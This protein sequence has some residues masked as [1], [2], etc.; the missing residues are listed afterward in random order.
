L[1][2]RPRDQVP[3]VSQRE[4][5]YRLKLKVHNVA[6]WPV[7][8]IAIFLKRERLDARNRIRQFLVDLVER[9]AVGRSERQ[10]SEYQKDKDSDQG[11]QP[12][13]ST[14]QRTFRFANRSWTARETS[15][16]RL[17][18][19]RGSATLRCSHTSS[20]AVLNEAPILPLCGKECDKRYCKYVLTCL[21]LRVLSHSPSFQATF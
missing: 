16:L 3:S 8:P 20:R 2:Y 9:F 1:R 11:N 7:Q 10:H 21:R 13:V 15:L 19:E 6:F 18:A 17:S 4:W 5:Q 14:L 12:R